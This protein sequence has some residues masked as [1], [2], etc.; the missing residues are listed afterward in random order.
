LRSDLKRAPDLLRLGKKL[1]AGRHIHELP[2]NCNSGRYVTTFCM[3]M[4]PMIK[5]L[6][7]YVGVLAQQTACMTHTMFVSTCPVFGYVR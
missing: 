3:H 1:N 2:L 7:S 6:P 4:L 5:W